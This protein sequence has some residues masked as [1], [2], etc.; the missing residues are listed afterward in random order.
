MAFTLVPALQPPGGRPRALPAWQ[1][2]EGEGRVKQGASGRGRGAGPRAWRGAEG[3]GPRA[4]GG[5]GGGGGPGVPSRASLGPG[6]SVAVGSGSQLG[7]CQLE[8]GGRTESGG[9]RVELQLGSCF[10]SS[11]PAGTRSAWLPAE[12]GVLS[13]DVGWPR[14]PT[15]PRYLCLCVFVF[16]TVCLNCLFLVKLP[17][18]LC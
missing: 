12:E 14:V 15:L 10:A 3:G 4:G 1:G 7:R 2:K 17:V 11:C 5:V 16:K 8:G 13:H 9:R 18:K 6:W